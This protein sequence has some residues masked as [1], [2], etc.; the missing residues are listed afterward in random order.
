MIRFPQVVNQNRSISH[1]TFRRHTMGPI[2]A[3]LPVLSSVPV[4]PV[5]SAMRAIPI[6]GNPFDPDWSKKAKAHAA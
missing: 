2:R 4:G 3:L 6:L 5:T 1:F